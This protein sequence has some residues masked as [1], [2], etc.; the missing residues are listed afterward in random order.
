MR[1]RYTAYAKGDID[2]LVR[3]HMHP[4]PDVLRED[5]SV[6]IRRQKWLRLV[7][8]EAE[9]SGNSGFVSFS[10]TYVDGGRMGELCERSE[11]VRRKGR[12]FY[13]KGESPE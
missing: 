13:L 2:Y 9:S 3:T 6:A 5:L 12:W 4:E 8:H 10:A 1:S 11:F 7:V